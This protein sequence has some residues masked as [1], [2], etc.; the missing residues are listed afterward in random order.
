MT[1]AGLIKAIPNKWKQKINFGK[2]KTNFTVE[3][4]N[5]YKNP[6]SKLPCNKSWEKISSKDKNNIIIQKK[7]ERPTCQK[8]WECKLCNYNFNPGKL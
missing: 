4:K 6:F 8:T 2:G 1:Y 5:I 3:L 7:K